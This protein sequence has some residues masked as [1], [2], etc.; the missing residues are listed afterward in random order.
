MEVPKNNIQNGEIGFDGEL[1][2]N[3]SRDESLDAFGMMKDSSRIIKKAKRPSK[4]SP[5]RDVSDGEEAINGVATNLQASIA[6]TKNSRK[7]RNARGRGL[8]KKG[9]NYS[10]LSVSMKT[11]IFSIYMHIVVLM[12]SCICLQDSYKKKTFSVLQ[13]VCCSPR[14][15]SYQ[16]QQSSHVCLCFANNLLNR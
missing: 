11:I 6:F 8:P 12:P 7:S 2:G 5:G 3:T 13:I 15:Y 14:V 1:N 16:Y 4:Q 10:Y 9:E